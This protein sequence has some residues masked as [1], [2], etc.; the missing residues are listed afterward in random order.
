MRM[1][2]LFYSKTGATDRGVAAL[3]SSSVE[4]T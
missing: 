1:I 3:V 4:H 2:T